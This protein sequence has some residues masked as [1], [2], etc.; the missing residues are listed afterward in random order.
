MKSISYFFYYL[1]REPLEK[2]QENEKNLI[3][4]NLFQIFT[5]ASFADIN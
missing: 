3:Q 2:F 1:F 5:T 4:I